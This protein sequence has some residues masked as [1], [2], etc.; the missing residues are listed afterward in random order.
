MKFWDY[1]FLPGVRGTATFAGLLT[2]LSVGMFTRWEFGVIGGVGVAVLV[3][4]VMPLVMYLQ[5]LPFEKMKRGLEGPFRFDE[6]VLFRS[7]RGSFGGYM[8]LSET[9]LVILTREKKAR[10]CMQLTPADVRSVHIDNT[11][12]LRI[13]LSETQYI[14]VL[15]G[16]AEEIF[17]FLSR[18]GWNTVKN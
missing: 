12:T 6:Q 16:V 10:I 17:E 13:F 11:T 3:T 4:L 9:A 7:P 8:L 18:H 5:N 15:C 2:G 14:C 1:F